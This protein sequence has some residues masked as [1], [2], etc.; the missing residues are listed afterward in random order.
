M[1]DCRVSFDIVGVA[2]AFVSWGML[3]FVT[4]RYAD[5][6]LELAGRSYPMFPLCYIEA[7]SG[8]L[9]IIYLSDII[10]KSN[11]FLL[12]QLSLWG[13]CSLNIL[14]IHCVDFLWKDLYMVSD[15]LWVNVAL[16][17]VIDITLFYVYKTIKTKY[18]R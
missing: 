6:G 9:V 13:S 14:M 2:V 15:Y 18:I 1:K 10:S 8:T 4:N 5:W 3:W 12:L 17:V 11:N 7:L 16:R